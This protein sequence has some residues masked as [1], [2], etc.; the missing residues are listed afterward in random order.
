MDMQLLNR[1][2]SARCSLM[3]KDRIR[4]L[5][6]EGNILLPTGEQGKISIPEYFTLSYE[7]DIKCFGENITFLRVDVRQ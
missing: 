5:D 2:E 6:A 1:I 7:Q 3:A 4:V